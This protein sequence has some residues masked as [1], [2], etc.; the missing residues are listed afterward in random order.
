MFFLG[1]GGDYRISG[2]KYVSCVCS[3]ERVV[4]VVAPRSPFLKGIFSD[5][6]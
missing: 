3:R 1:G 5:A 2:I 6:L 4:N